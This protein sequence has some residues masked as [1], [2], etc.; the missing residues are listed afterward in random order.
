M[1]DSNLTQDDKLRALGIRSPEAGSDI[2]QDLF[3]TIQEAFDSLDEFEDEID[4]FTSF[5]EFENY[6]VNQGILDAEDAERLRQRIEARFGDYQ[7][8]LDEI[9]SADTFNEW[10]SQYNPGGGVTGGSNQGVRFHEQ[11]GV[12]RNG[13]QV[14]A[15]TVEVYGARVEFSETDPSANPEISFTTSNISASSTTIGVQTTQTFD[16]FPEEVVISA[17]VTNTSG[18]EAEITSRLY[19]DDE[20]VE[21]T[22]STFADGETVEVSFAVRPSGLG[23]HDFRINQSDSVTI[24]VDPSNSPVP[25]PPDLSYA[26]FTLSPDSE[27]I[28]STDTPFLPQSQ[29]TA[30]I[31]NESGYPV[32]AFIDLFVEGESVSQKEIEF[33]TGETR[34]VSFVHT[35]PISYGDYEVQIENGPTK[36]F[37]VRYA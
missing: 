34:E 4:N 7:S 26:N 33:D 18:G 23:Q 30:D 19:E 12:S 1:V 9:D 28:G 6:L 22:T 15:G 35:F 21:T 32:T 37:E 27:T 29:I 14:P 11:A 17:D 25:I 36:T 2:S 8:L 3:E 24:T 13:I 16:I 5:D 31:T 10:I 20:E